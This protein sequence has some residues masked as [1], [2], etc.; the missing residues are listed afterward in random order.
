MSQEDERINSLLGGAVTFSAPENW[1][2]LRHI[3]TKERGRVE[4]E[5]RRPGLPASSAATT[6]TTATTTAPVTAPA[7]VFLTAYRISDAKATI[8]ALSDGVYKNNY[9]GL[10]VLSDAF[11]GDDWRTIVW[12]AKAGTSHLMLQR[13]GLRNQQA[14]ELWVALP[15]ET[16]VDAKQLEQAVADFNAAAESLK[17]EGRNSF[18]ARVS[19]AKL[20]DQL[21]VKR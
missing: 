21:K 1:T 14:V 9:E 6:A 11:D 15:L 13:Y 12:T 16:A 10:A 5:V 18:G 8:R 3:S 20:L 2:Q 7:R 4:Y 19:A 17:I